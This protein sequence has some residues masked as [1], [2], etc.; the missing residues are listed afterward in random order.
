ME[1]KI[2]QHTYTLTTEVY[3]LEQYADL[4]DMTVEEVLEYEHGMCVG[5]INAMLEDETTGYAFRLVR[6]LYA[7]HFLAIAEATS[8]ATLALL[9]D[10]FEHLHSNG[11]A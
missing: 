4:M 7:T 3:S 9:D 5:C 10:Y 8:A 6:S 2:T 11:L 1:N